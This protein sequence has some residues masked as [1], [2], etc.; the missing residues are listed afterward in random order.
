LKIIS[1][2]HAGLA[3]IEEMELNISDLRIVIK[4]KY[5]E[6]DIAT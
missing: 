3:C 4:Y 6:C 5:F 2:R 1:E